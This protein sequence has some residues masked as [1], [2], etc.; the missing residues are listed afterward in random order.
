MDGICWMWDG[1]RKS[2]KHAVTAFEKMGRSRDDSPHSLVRRQWFGRRGTDE[3]CGAGAA[4]SQIDSSLH[5]TNAE[6]AE[7]GDGKRGG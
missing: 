1:L 2:S 3:V 5:W 6:G 4:G 7:T